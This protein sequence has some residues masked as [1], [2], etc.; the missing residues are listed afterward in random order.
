MEVPCSR[1]VTVTVSRESVA[2][3][4]PVW[5]ETSVPE[6]LFDPQSIHSVDPLTKLVE[7]EVTVLEGAV[8]EE[9]PV[10]QSGQLV[11]ATPPDTVVG[12]V[13]T[14]EELFAGTT[15]DTEF[16]TELRSV[17]EVPEDVAV[18]SEVVSET[19]G[20]LVEATEEKLEDSH[21]GQYV[22]VFTVEAVVEGTAELFVL[23]ELPETTEESPTLVD[24]SNEELDREE[25]LEATTEVPVTLGETTEEVLED[26]Q[27]GQ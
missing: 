21:S 11:D 7:V 23:A 22:D 6:E 14:P 13:G 27:S 12:V 24:T 3:T 1:E 15:I 25:E 20:T 2:E 18:L 9:A 19:T 8:S 17:S 10:S 16:S 26:S 5:F 4:L